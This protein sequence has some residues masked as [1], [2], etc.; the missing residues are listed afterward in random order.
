MKPILIDKIQE[1]FGNTTTEAKAQDDKFVY[2]GWVFAKPMNYDP[3]YFTMEERQAMANA[4][5]EGKA[6]AVC[7]F[8]DLSDEDKVEYLKS[9]LPK[10]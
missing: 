8:E 6:I 4:V 5:L 3:E 10:K 2:G 7:F 9:K 1:E